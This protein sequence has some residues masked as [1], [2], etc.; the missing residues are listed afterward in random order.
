MFFQVKHT[1]SFSVTHDFWQYILMTFFMRIYCQECD[2]PYAEI[3]TFK[4]DIFLRTVFK[5]TFGTK[6]SI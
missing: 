6:T 4:L 3:A 1:K 5:S 2:T